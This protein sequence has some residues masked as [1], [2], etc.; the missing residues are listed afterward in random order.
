M[1][2]VEKISRPPGLLN[3]EVK[4]A[5]PPGILE[6]EVEGSYPYAADPSGV[7]V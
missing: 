5:S 7:Q 2:R 6:P 4:Q 1:M 3:F